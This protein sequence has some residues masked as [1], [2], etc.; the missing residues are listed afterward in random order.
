[1]TLEEFW[2]L[3]DKV[4][5]EAGEDMDE[6][7]RVLEE[8]LRRMPVEEVLSFLNHFDDCLDRAYTWDLWAAAH[9]IGGGCGDDSFSDFRSTLI[10]M[11]KAIF[12][13]ALVDPESLC[14][15]PIEDPEYFM[16]ESFHYPALSVYQEMTGTIPIRET[17]HPAE[18]AGLEW[19]EEMLDM[20]YP[21]LAKKFAIHW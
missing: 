2:K 10:S 13:R 1:M 16:Y 17:P 9:I 20:K 7:C 18:P 21:R 5:R 8:K 11:G 12:E 3:I 6:K 19:Q 14:E 15:L 4:N